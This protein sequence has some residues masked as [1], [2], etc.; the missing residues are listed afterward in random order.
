MQLEDAPGIAQQHLAFGSQPHL[1][2]VA[3]EQL[4]LQNVFF[5]A[6]HLHAHRRL[7]AV[8]HLAS[9]G[10]TALIGNRD[11]GAQDIGID[12]G[13]GRQLMNLRDACHQKHSL[14]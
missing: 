3:L 7:G 5:Q 9:T 11:K 4:A 2:A 10:E 14:D 13:V 1:A 8:D 6:F 12:T